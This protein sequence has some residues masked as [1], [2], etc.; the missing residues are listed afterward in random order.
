MT[1][2]ITFPPRPRAEQ[3]GLDAMTDALERGEN[4]DDAKTAGRKA[5]QD[6]LTDWQQQCDAVKAGAAVKVD[7]LRQQATVLRQQAATLIEQATTL[8]KQADQIERE[9]ADHG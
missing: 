7:N 8:T 4:L 3:V 6:A 9:V 5:A 2:E 1:H